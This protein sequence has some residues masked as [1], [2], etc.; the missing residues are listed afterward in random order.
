MTALA[1]A[2]QRGTGV[3]ARFTLDDL[4]E[5]RGYIAAT[6]NHCNDRKLRRE[7]D[8]LFARLTAEIDRY[9][10]GQ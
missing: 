3:I 4:D 7:L 10:D 1:V 6:A 8:A 9:D 2:E 5:L